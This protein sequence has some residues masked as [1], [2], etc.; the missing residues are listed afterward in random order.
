MFRIISATAIMLL[1]TTTPQVSAE[2]ATEYEIKGSME[3]EVVGQTVI[4]SEDGRPKVYSHIKGLETGDN[5]GFRYSVSV[6]PDSDYSIIAVALWL[7]IQQ[8]STL[9]SDHH[10][11]EDEFD[12]YEQ[13]RG[14]I[15][16]ED[17]IEFFNESMHVRLE[18]YYK[19]DWHGIATD[20]LVDDM[21]RR[22]MVV[23]CR[24]SE[25]NWDLFRK[26]ASQ[27]F[28]SYAD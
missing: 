7:H 1:L 24:Q 4:Q 5:V 9:Y 11:N 23:D 27:A 20:Y 17:Y 8:F 3:C 15:V 22:S 26:E 6:E 28:D 2:E 25:N 10:G 21:V 16:S 14:L 18:R 13:S 19:S 12:L